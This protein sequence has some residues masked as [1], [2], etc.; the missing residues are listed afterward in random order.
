[1]VTNRK[2]YKVLKH[3]FSMTSRLLKYAIML[4]L[5]IGP[6]CATANQDYSGDQPTPRYEQRVPAPR[7]DE[8]TP[9]GNL[10]GSVTDEIRILTKNIFNS[11]FF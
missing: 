10:E 11:L 9:K 2:V 8:V 4:P 1:M 7:R 3:E 6:G 5:L